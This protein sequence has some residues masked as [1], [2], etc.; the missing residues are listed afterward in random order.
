MPSMN[1]RSADLNLLLA[2]H[3]LIEKIQDKRAADRFSL[4]QS[5]MSRVLQRLRQPPTTIFSLRTRRGLSP[6]PPLSGYHT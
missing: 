3:F 4:S 1:L 2:L 5:V 6:I